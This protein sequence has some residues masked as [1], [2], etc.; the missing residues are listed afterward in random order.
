MLNTSNI[1]LLHSLFQEELQIA[2]CIMRPSLYGLIHFSKRLPSNFYV[3]DKSTKINSLTFFILY[4]MYVSSIYICKGPIL[5]L[6]HTEIKE[7]WCICICINFYVKDKSTKFNAITF[8]LM[9]LY[10]CIYMRKEP[11]MFLCHTCINE[12][13]CIYI[14]YFYICIFVYIYFFTFLYLCIYMPKEPFMFLCHTCIN[15]N[16]CMSILYFYLCIFVS[17]CMCQNIK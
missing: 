17:M 14:L 8:F 9:F 16:W 4:F 1:I 12:N 3:K 7:N 15:E 5:F 13:W 11:F 2:N 10:L 6:C